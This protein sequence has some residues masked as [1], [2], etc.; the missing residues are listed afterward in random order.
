MKFRVTARCARVR[1]NNGIVE[2]L[3]VRSPEFADANSQEEHVLMNVDVAH[4][5]PEEGKD[6]WFP[7]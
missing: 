3:F 4:G 5:L 2:A 7:H 1:A 6:Y